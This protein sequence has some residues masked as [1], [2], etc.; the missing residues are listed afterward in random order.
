MMMKMMTTK[1][2]FNDY[3]YITIPIRHNRNVFTVIYF[4]FVLR[5][6]LEVD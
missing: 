4:S 3:S 1:I 5:V 2:S 6:V